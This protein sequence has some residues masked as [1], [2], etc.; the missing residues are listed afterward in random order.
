MSA[1]VPRAQLFFESIAGPIETPNLGLRRR[2]GNNPITMTEYLSIRRS[3]AWERLLNCQDAGF[4]RRPNDGFV[5]GM[6]VGSDRV[7]GFHHVAIIAIFRGK[8]T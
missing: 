3:Q 1:G 2:P 4:L 7:G 5:D 6:L 8:R